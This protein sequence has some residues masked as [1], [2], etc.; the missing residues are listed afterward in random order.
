MSS[1]KTNSCAILIWDVPKELKKKFKAQCALKQTT[2]KDAIREL[3]IAY[4]NA[5]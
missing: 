5:R 4:I 3:M 1:S 2:M